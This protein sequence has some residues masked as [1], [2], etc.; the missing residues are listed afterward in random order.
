[1]GHRD[2]GHAAIREDAL[3]LN[4]ATYLRLGELLALQQPRSDPHQHDEMLFIVFHQVSE[5]WFKQVLH[6]LDALRVALAGG[7][8][9]AA[10]SVLARLR[11]ILRVLVSQLD[12]L[13]TMTPLSFSAFRDRLERASG[14][15]S[16]QFREIEF[17][18]GHKQAELLDRYPPDLPGLDRARRR[19]HEPSIVDAFYDFLEHHEVAIPARCRQRDVTE[20]TQPDTA[21][22]DGIFDRYVADRELRIVFELMTD[23]DQILQEWRYRHVKVV[24]RTIGNKPGSGGTSGVSYLRS[25]LFQPVFPDLWAIRHR[26]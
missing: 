18:L 14:L 9:F 12:V 3:A 8:T 17:L 26:L 21:V 24:E 7:R 6:E 11:R 2:P 20:P 16:M 1:M 19:L 5:L 13:E 15:Q 25:T 22:Q 4:Y 10:T 23:V